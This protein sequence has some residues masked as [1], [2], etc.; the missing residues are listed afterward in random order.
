MK[1]LLVIFMI[2]LFS[3]SAF[4]AGVTESDFRKIAAIE[5]EFL[6]AKRDFMNLGLKAYKD[7]TAFNPPKSASASD[8]PAKYGMT[9]GDYFKIRTR[10]LTAYKHWLLSNPEGQE[11]SELKKDIGELQTQIDENGL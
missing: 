6:A 9:L 5:I 4:S 11:L 10:N 2:G 3:H 7:S 8:I 1:R